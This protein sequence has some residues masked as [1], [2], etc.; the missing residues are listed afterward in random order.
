MERMN[1]ALKEILEE[2]EIR[3][4]KET[5]IDKSQLVNAEYMN[6]LREDFRKTLE[7]TIEMQ[8]KKRKDE[9]RDID[10]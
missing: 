4:E 8:H 2:R 9:G 1:Q 7:E 6:S 3:R 5:R 10:D